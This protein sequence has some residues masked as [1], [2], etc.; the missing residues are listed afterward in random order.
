MQG[1]LH[2]CTQ[3]THISNMWTCCWRPSG[4]ALNTGAQA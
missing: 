4:H 2:L 1:C 3:K